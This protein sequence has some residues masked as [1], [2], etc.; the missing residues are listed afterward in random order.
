[1]EDPQ[2]SRYSRV[3]YAIS[4]SDGQAS[5]ANYD[6]PFAGTYSWYVSVGAGKTVRW[7]NAPQNATI[8][9]NS[10]WSFVTNSVSTLTFSQTQTQTQMQTQMVAATTSTFSTTSTVTQQD[11][12]VSMGTCT[13]YTQVSWTTSTVTDQEPYTVGLSTAYQYQYQT[14]SQI[15]TA[16]ATQTASFTVTSNYYST[17]SFTVPVST[18]TTAS[19]TSVTATLSQTVLKSVTQTRYVYVESN[20]SATNPA[21]QRSPEA[22]QDPLVGLLR[23]LPLPIVGMVAGG[24][25]CATLLF[26]R[27]KSKRASKNEEGEEE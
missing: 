3:G 7:N 25:V 5:V 24:L 8:T 27:L 23:S 21:L 22:I 16:F 26:Y 11:P 9:G 1:M 12:C 6:P 17:T 10:P 14:I 18:V 19:I 2:S 20:A 15:V 13:T 4:G